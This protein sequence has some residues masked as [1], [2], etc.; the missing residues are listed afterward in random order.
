[1]RVSCKGFLMRHTVFQ[2]HSDG[3]RYCCVGVTTVDICVC[4]SPGRD[5]RT[6]EESLSPSNE[7]K[8]KNTSKKRSAT[9]GIRMG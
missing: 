1:M 8:K 3:R 6:K 5:M 4:A 7:S 2:F 9:K